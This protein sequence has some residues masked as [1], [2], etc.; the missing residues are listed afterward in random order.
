MANDIPQKTNKPEGQE[1]PSSLLIHYVKSP[2]YR[3]VHADGIFGGPSPNL[4]IH[5]SFWSERAPIP[6]LIEHK[7]N[8][9]GTLGEEVLEG[10]ISKSGL[11]REVD[12]DVVMNLTTARALK[13]WLEEKIGHV[14]RMIQRADRPPV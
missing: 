2:M 4:N 7:V 8:P 3:T 12:V 9:D 6:Q 14:E 5:L 13:D 1:L 10:R 11:V